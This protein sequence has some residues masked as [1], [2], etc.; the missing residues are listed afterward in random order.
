[1][2]FKDWRHSKNLILEAAKTLGKIKLPSKK[3]SDV[4]LGKYK[5]ITMIAKN[6]AIERQLSRLHSMD[7]IIFA[8]KK[9]I[10]FMLS[11]PG[12]QKYEVLIYSM[13]LGAGITYNPKFNKKQMIIT[14]VLPKK[15][16][17]KTVVSSN[18]KNR[19]NPETVESQP[20]ITESLILDIESFLLTE[21]NIHVKLYF[22]D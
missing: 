12:E 18:F 17:S 6:H 16:V 5:G 13:K 8:A 22:I 10:D 7:N 20:F 2:E 11:K 19:H 1:M 4:S 15:A 9:A 3:K 21:S 14:T